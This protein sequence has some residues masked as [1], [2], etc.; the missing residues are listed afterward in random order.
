MFVA[1]ATFSVPRCFSRF[2][3][4]NLFWN[5]LLLGVPA[6]SSLIPSSIERVVFSSLVPWSSVAPV[7]EEL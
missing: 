5:F 1:T 6:S 2:F 7:A 4:K 3:V